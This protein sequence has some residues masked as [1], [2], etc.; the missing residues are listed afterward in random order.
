MSCSLRLRQSMATEG[1]P[2]LAPALRKN[3][4]AIGVWRLRF[5]GTILTIPEQRLRREMMQ[6]RSHRPWDNRMM[7][8]LDI[9]AVISKSPT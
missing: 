2:R 4:P 7:G 5:T 3:K 9:A 1:K 8:S 6:I